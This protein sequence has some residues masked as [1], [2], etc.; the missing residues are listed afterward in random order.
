MIRMS[1]ASPVQVSRNAPRSWVSEWGLWFIM[2]ALA[3]LGMV[4]ALNSIPYLPTNDGPEHILSG[5]IENHYNDPGTIYAQHLTPL[6]QYAGRGFALLYVPLE[7][8]LGWRLATQVVL[9]I[10]LLVN[11]WG[12]AWL[13]NSIDSRRKWIALLA[14]AFGFP[15]ALYMGFFP[16]LA[17]TAFGTS[18]VAFVVSR[19]QESTLERV[20][21]AAA[22]GWQAH[23]HL[24]TA[25]VTGLLLMPIYLLRRPKEEWQRQIVPF[26]AMI[27]P[28]VLMFALTLR[29]QAVS[30]KQSEVPVY[31]GSIDERLTV[32]PHVLAPGAVWKGILLLLLAAIG[33]RSALRR[34]ENGTAHR[35][36]KGL[37]VAAA[38]FMALG[39]LAPLNIPGWQFLNPRFLIVGAT[40]A[41][42]LLAIER[43]EPRTWIPA[44][45]MAPCLV[46]LVSLLATRELHRQLDEGCADALSGLDQ[47]ITRS[48][49]QVSMR[50]DSS[51]GIPRDPLVSEI[52]YDTPLE[53]LGCVYAAQQG[54]TIPSFFIGHPAIHAFAPKEMTDDLPIPQLKVPSVAELEDP[55]LRET[56]ITYFAA[57]AAFYESFLV[58]GASKND[59]DTILARG[60][61]PRW[62]QGSFLIAEYQGC[63]VSLTVRPPS[64]PGRLV[65]GHGM[66]PLGQ[67]VWSSPTNLKPG[68]G[69]K[70]KLDRIGCGDVWVK[71]ALF[72]A[73]QAF[74]CKG[75]TSG[76]R[77]EL[78]TSRIPVTL[79]CEL[80]T[81]M[82]SPKVPGTF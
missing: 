54:G 1:I 13:V 60:F 61:V 5:H 31:F 27:S 8:A 50:L 59:Q 32:L 11:A 37:A 28:V 17:G 80:S 33:I 25:M 51:C 42:P 20:I 39:L 72:G 48:Y 46:T 36:E 24:F 38:L 6:S 81:T 35:D 15:W 82:P 29:D 12:V 68:Q 49:V 66:T 26:A 67:P 65:V 2:V 55:N 3:S 22:L 70:I 47:P 79:N 76:G 44:S 53:H 10:V 75:S 18:I 40:F 34:A 4:W 62:Q 9:S 30:P 73:Q 63:S 23:L 45:A 16:Y 74:A 21:V 19:K 41:I 7:K 71:V 56:V 43:I 57:H 52:P 77:I 64:E 14:F 58:F 78:H 69:V